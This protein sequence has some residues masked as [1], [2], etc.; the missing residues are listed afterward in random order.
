MMPGIGTVDGKPQ[1]PLPLGVALVYAILSFMRYT[2][3][4]IWLPGALVVALVHLLKTP[5]M[6]LQPAGR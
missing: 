5:H 4:V 2:P 3:Q 1:H 6:P